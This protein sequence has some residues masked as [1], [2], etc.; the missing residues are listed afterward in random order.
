LI[1]SKKLIKVFVSPRVRAT[2][3][4]ELLLGE[5]LKILEKE[6]KV[7]ITNALAEM[8]YGD[9]E[10]LKDHEIRALRKERGLDTEREWNIWA[11]ACENGE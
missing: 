1:D 8:L 2:V 7:E 3:T 11:D 10:G 6:G 9:Y 5:E 4:S